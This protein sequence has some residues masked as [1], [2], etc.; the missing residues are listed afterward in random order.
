MVNFWQN[1]PKPFLALAPMA[2][3]TDTAFRQMCKLYGADVI[4]TEFASADA[5]IYE[6]KKTKEFLSFTDSE[7]P[8]VCQIFG[9]EPNKFYK[10]AAILE[11]MGFD[12]LDINF[13]CPAY[14]VVKNGGGVSLMRNLKLYQEIVQ[15]TCEGSNLPVSIKIRASIKKGQD[16][17]DKITAGGQGNDSDST[18]CLN[19]SIT[20][21]DLVS[22]IKHLPVSAIMLHARSFEQPFDG[23]PKLEILEQVRQIWPG[24]L[25]ANGG[26]ITP[27][28]AIETLKQTKVDGLG[29]ARGAWGK[30]WLF[31]QIKDYLATNT[32]HTPLWPEIKQIMLQHAKLALQT[33]GEHG[34]IELRKHLSWYVKGFTNASDIRS[35]LVQIK[36]LDD[37]KKILKAS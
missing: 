13:G 24:L 16:T 19:N 7:R 31:K 18:A 33:K 29:I 5:L 8:V 3:V 21:V 9:R 36:T 17:K 22:Q 37:V 28:I 27:E 20:A 11:Q 14:K 10:A 26:L 15:A 12:G 1:L 25:I 30:P 2:G 34:L 35:Q 32:Y 4:Y 23:Q 6:N